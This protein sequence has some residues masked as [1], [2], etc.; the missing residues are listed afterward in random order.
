MTNNI[1]IENHIKN[2]IFEKKMELSGSCLKRFNTAVINK[3]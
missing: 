2:R 1:L 3:Y